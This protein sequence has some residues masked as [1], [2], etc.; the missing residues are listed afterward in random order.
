M[1]GSAVLDAAAKLKARI[2]AAAATEARDAA[3]EVKIG[4]G[5]SATF[6][7]KTLSA[8]D[9]GKMKVQADGEFSNH[10]H[11]YAY[12]AAAAHVTVDPG[13]GRVELLDYFN[14]EDLGRVINPLTAQG[15]AVGAVVQGLGG[16]F[17]EH[18]AYDEEG[19]FLAGTFADYLMPS[20]MDF[21]Q[22]R[23]MVLEN[24]PSPH[25]PLGA[26]GGGEGGIVPVGGVVA[27]AVAAAL[28]S[29]DVEPNTLPLT[30]PKVWALLQQASARATSFRTRPQDAIRNPS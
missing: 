17:L 5:L 4:R 28:S 27:N 18:L 23:A 7:G 22:V 10:H 9:L 16:T 8:S 2:R 21:P 29:L 14:V 24:S 19:Q 1:G 6:R 30:P 11:T 3:E 12:G 15:Q 25:N 20:A 26:K 13:T